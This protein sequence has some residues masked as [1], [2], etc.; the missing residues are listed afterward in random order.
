MK[1]ILLALLSAVLFQ[2][3]FAAD[4]ACLSAAAEKKLSGAAQ[5]SF[6]KKCVRD[7]CASKQEAGGRRP[8]QLHE[9]V[10]VRAMMH[11]CRAR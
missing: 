10:P 1:A 9:Q 11:P 4:S 8:H 5:N 3:A 7:A 6:V 2:P